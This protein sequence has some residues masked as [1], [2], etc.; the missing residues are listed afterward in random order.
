MDAGPPDLAKIVTIFLVPNS[1][2]VGTLG[3]ARTEGLKT[4]VSVLGL[5]A[6][7]LW[8]ICGMDALG[9]TRRE[10][11]LALLPTLFIVCWLIAGAIHAKLWLKPANANT[12]TLDADVAA[13]FPD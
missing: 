10:L 4:G 5:V 7:I 11:V 8:L 9:T 1:I 12:V 2:L 3:V 6:S 13:A